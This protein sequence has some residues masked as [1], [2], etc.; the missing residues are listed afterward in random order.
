E[1]LGDQ[2]GYLTEGLEVNI[3][4]FE[5]KPVGVQLPK[6]VELKV[7]SAPPAVRGDTAQG[8]ITKQVTLETGLE[9]HVPIFV[10]EGDTIRINTEKNEY[11]ERV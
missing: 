8:S 7:V 3:L 6:K 9:I 1:N 5:N 4:Y 2:I 10:K 11:A